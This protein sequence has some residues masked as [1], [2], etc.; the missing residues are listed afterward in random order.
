M[1]MS[2]QYLIREPKT[3]Q[4]KNPLLLLLHGY[5]SN[6]EDLFSFASELPEQYYVISVQ[7]PHDLMY[8]S[9][10]W[11]AINFDADDTK[12][13]DI[14]QAKQSRDLIVDFIDE[15]VAK[16]PIDKENI[17]LIGF[18]QGAI[19]SY[20]IALSYP[21]K[22]SK[23]VAMS[24]YLNTEMAKDNFEKNNFS[25]L[26]IFASHG[27]V[28]QVIPVDWARKTSPVLEKLG[29]KF[30]YKEYPVG[31]GVAPQNFYDFRNWLGENK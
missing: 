30:V 9:Y 2:L 22:V 23:I 5:G 3:I 8:G 26:K 31:H 24:G 27:T 1:I 11:Y 28:D 15:L 20:A 6:K 12:F 16:F 4:E 25:N 17:T 13:S 21:E 14:N 29:I 18:S 19:L 10:A 7:A